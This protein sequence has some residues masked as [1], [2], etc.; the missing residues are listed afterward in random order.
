M[1]AS[2]AG[3]V[4]YVNVFG[5][6]SYV[7]L[8]SPALV[9]YYPATASS[10]GYVFPPFLAEAA[11]HEFGHNQG[12]GHDTQ[13]GNSYYGG[14]GSG[15]VSWGPIMGTGYNRNVSQWSKGEYSGADNTQDDLAI[16]DNKMGYRVDDHG[17]S[18]TTA[19]A[20]L[21]DGA[22]NIPSTNPE[23]DPFN[24]NPDNKGIIELRSDVDMFYFDAAAGTVSLSIIPAWD[25]FERPSNDRGANLDIQAT[26]YDATGDA[27]TSSD[28]TNDTRAD[29]STTVSQGRY[30]LGITG[31]GNSFSPYTDYGSLGFYYIFGSV[32]PQNPDTTAPTPTTMTWASVP[33]AQGKYAITMTAVTASDDSG[34]VEYNFLCV[35]GGQGCADSGWQ[36]STSF[37][38]NGLA[39]GNS[40][41]FQVK[42]RDG[43][44]NENTASATESATTDAE[45]IPANPSN[46]SATVNST[47]Q[48]NLTWI[49]T[50]DNE[51]SFVIER[52]LDVITGW[53]L[54]AT[55]PASSTSHSDNG[56]DHSTEYF[57]RLKAVNDAGDSAYVS[58]SATTS[59]PPAFIDYTAIS[60]TPSSGTVSGTYQATAADDDSVQSITERDSGG[61]PQN[62][63]DYLTHTWTFNISGGNVVSLFAN[64]WVTGGSEDAFIF[65]VSVNGGNFES[66]FTVFS[67]SNTNEQSAILSGTTGVI[68]VRVRDSDQTAGYRSHQAIVVD[69][70]YIR[71]ENAVGGT[72][73]N[74]PTGLTAS[75]DSSS[76]IT[77]DW[78]DTANN[79]SGFTIERSLD[80]SAWSVIDTAGLNAT[81]YTDTGLDSETLYYYR[82]KAFNATGDSGY[83]DTAS[84]TTDV[85]SPITLSA[86]GFKD[87]GKHNVDLTWSGANG[88]DVY[89]Y[90][91]ED[92][93]TTTNDGNYTD[94]IGTKGGATYV[95]KVCE[96]GTPDCSDEVTVIF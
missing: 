14:H 69:H 67:G 79:E 82:V 62:R 87:K 38:A 52:S 3:G 33:A 80:N 44:L 16:M 66:A 51:N 1:P 41:G 54:I 70:M 65:E 24:N 27:I 74:D 90:R 64:A 78:A 56:L 29:I 72:V 96:T 76:Q 5:S 8:Y 68:N 2:G 23:T 34:F 36:T 91:N 47:S 45:T 95:Y 50:A 4:A 22:G 92:L 9:Y 93:F 57:Y 73:P 37:T 26:L 58:T 46:F 7:N 59:S 89:I 28:P 63:Y 86:T 11:S 81:R 39:A 94:N 88:S 18:I 84:A 60:E 10:S 21:V 12:M 77:I 25:A 75:A 30:Y 19:T 53:S 71:V 85:A 17:D 31:V 20:L 48:I 55:L 42:A 15:L 35:S 6:S 43:S 61:R 13:Y 32:V 40:Y 83:T 49:D